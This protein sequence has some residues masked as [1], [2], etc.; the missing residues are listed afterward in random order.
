[1]SSIHRKRWKKTTSQMVVGNQSISESFIKYLKE[2]NITFNDDKRN[3]FVG[4]SIELTFEIKI[5]NSK[6]NYKLNERKSYGFDG[7]SSRV[8]LKAFFKDKKE[9]RIECEIKRKKLAFFWRR[10]FQTD[11]SQAILN[12]DEI[13]SF[14]KLGGNKIIF[15]SIKPY[16]TIEFHSTNPSCSILDLINSLINDYMSHC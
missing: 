12:E 2:K 8:R 15:Q 1:M 4:D 7:I 13:S 10:K 11:C 9:N 3:F 6:I 16:Q 14:F 5:G